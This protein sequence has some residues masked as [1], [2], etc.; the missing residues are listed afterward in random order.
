MARVGLSAIHHATTS[1]SETFPRQRSSGSSRPGQNSTRSSAQTL[2][3]DMSR[4]SKIEERRW[5]PAIRTRTGRSGRPSTCP[6]SSRASRKSLGR[7]AVLLDSLDDEPGADRRGERPLRGSRTVLG[8][9]AVRDARHR[10]STSALLLDLDDAERVAL[11]AV[12]KYLVMRYDRLFGTPFPYSM[13]V[14]QAPTTGARARAPICICTSTHRC[15][16]QRASASSWSATNSSPS[17]NATSPPRR[18]RSG[19]GRRRR[20]RC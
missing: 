14:H 15:C 6:R 20:D 16:G 18:L 9:V 5:G 2:T 11:G 13:G 8:R 19:Y 3:S 7:S 4:S 10:P 12:L 1:V 17:P